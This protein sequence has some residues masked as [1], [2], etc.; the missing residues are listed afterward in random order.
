[1]KAASA[2]LQEIEYL[3]VR[4]RHAV[5]AGHLAVGDHRTARGFVEDAVVGHRVVQRRQL[6]LQQT[7]DGASG[8]FGEVGRQVVHGARARTERRHL[9]RGRVFS[10]DCQST[11]L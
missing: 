6:H 4:V 9:W 2:V 11:G 8:T 10:L 1:M 3:E 7:H 5:K